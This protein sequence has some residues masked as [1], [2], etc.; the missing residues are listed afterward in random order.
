[1]ATARLTIPQLLLTRVSPTFLA[2]AVAFRGRRGN[3]A[4]LPWAHQQVS[5]CS[6]SMDFRQGM[7]DAAA[8]FVGDGME[9][10]LVPCLKDNYA[11]IFHDSSTG[12]TAVVDTPEVGPILTAI[13]SRGWK[14]THILNT[15]HHW[16]HTGGNEEIKR[17]T[18]CTIVGPAGEATRIPGLDTAVKEG[19]RVKIGS[20]EAIVIE[21]GGHTAGHI[22]Y[23]FPSQKT[24][25][26][27]DTLFVL[28]CG[29]LFEGKPAQM[30][31]SLLKLR[32][33]PD[34]TVVY[35]AHEYTE[36]N[37][38]FAEHLGGAPEL[39]DRIEIIRDMR[40]KGMST[41][42]MLLRH[43]KETNPF[44]LADSERMR[45]TLGFPHGTT[46]VEVFTEVRRRKDQF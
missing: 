28:G 32:A 9:V 6:T 16:D 18:G 22:A 8:A 14:L 45:E 1:M 25:F 4:H 23:H 30:W 19:D 40:N 13:E 3:R 17:R 39:Q 38:R 42:P 35:C 20:F 43:E 33:L 10:H 15:H 21:V 11:P 24:A 44:L 31:T 41:V 26:V 5:A 27:G 29:R 2:A 36:A 7:G 46:P 34:E 37:A 12:A